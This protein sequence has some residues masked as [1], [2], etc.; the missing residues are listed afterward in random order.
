MSKLKKAIRKAFRVAVFTRA[1]YCC[2]WCGIK[3]HDRQNLKLTNVE[4][5]RTKSLDAH[6]ITDRHL[7][8]NGG[9]VPE[10]GVALCPKCHKKAERREIT[11]NQLYDIINSD[12]EK[13]VIASTSLEEISSIFG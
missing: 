2:E 8:P 6:H 4:I 11:G 3:G 12:Y 1:N 13:A 9:Y 7:M 10:N 5:A